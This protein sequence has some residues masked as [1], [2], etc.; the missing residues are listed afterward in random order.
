MRTQKGILGGEDARHSPPS[1]LLE[2]LADDLGI[3]DFSGYIGD[4][5]CPRELE[6]GETRLCFHRS[7][8]YVG[9]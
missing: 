4:H 2:V 7:G 8:G 5:Q 6:L 9:P 1:H 3:L